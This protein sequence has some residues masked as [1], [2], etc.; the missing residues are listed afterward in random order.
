M[1]RLQWPRFAALHADDMMLCVD[2]LRHRMVAG[3]RR[4]NVT[5][6]LAVAVKETVALFRF[7]SVF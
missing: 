4:M 3:R 5:T 1:R 7:P 2:D 6:R